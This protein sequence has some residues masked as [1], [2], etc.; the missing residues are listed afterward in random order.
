MPFAIRDAGGGKFKVVNKATGNVHSKA[1]TMAKARAQIGIMERAESDGNRVRTTKE[2]IGK[3]P[4][5]TLN[6]HKSKHKSKHK[7]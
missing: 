2:L 4:G 3:H 6:P 1:T 7:K 5:T